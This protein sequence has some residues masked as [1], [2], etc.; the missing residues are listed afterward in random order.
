M[1]TGFEYETVTMVYNLVILAWRVR[2]AL[3]AVIEDEP[4][5]LELL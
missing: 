3:I 5:L 1:I 4:D 2:M